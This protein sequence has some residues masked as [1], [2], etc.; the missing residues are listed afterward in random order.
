VAPDNRGFDLPVIRLNFRQL[1]WKDRHAKAKS[2]LVVLGARYF[3]ILYGKSIDYYPRDFL[4]YIQ[5]LFPM[6]FT[7]IIVKEING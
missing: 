3:L 1:L 6:D 7:L 5:R 2:F 4:V